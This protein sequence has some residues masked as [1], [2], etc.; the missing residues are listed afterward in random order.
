M[1]GL[2]ERILLGIFKSPKSGPQTV[3]Q[4]QTN[5]QTNT[6]KQTQSIKQPL[7]VKRNLSAAKYK[8]FSFHL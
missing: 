5:K 2:R 8:I 4:T 6:I 1:P 7:T 3:K